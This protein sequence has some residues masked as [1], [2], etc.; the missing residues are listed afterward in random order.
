MTTPTSAIE[1]RIIELRDVTRRLNLHVPPSY[2]ATSSSF[3]PYEDAIEPIMEADGDRPLHLY[4]GV[5]LCEEHCRFCMYFYRLVD[6][7]GDEADACVNGL[8]EYLDVIAQRTHRRIAAL[9][10]GGGRLR[11]SPRTKS[12]AS[13]TLSTRH[14][15]L[16][17]AANGPLSSRP[18]LPLRRSLPSL[19][20]AALVA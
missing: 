6:A 3:V 17:Q 7:E 2:F 11:Y 15:N 8:V 16:S 5:P 10:V 14:S 12:T 18:D 13:C 4:V 20:R 9:Y 19:Q 1:S